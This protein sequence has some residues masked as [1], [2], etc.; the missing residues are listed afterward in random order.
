VGTNAF[1]STVVLEA[2]LQQPPRNVRF[3][4]RT[5]CKPLYPRKRTFAVQKEMSALGQKRH[6]SAYVCLC[7]NAL[8]LFW[9]ADESKNPALVAG[10]FAFGCGG[11]QAWHARETAARWTKT[12]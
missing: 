1:I 10:F 12:P 8:D 6:R 7:E 3:V 9:L 5:S 11:P 4:K 2:S